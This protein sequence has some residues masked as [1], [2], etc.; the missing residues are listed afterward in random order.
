MKQ[1]FDADVLVNVG[2]M[3]SLAGSDE[4]KV[5]P[6]RGRGFRQPPRPSQRHADN[7]TVDQ[8]GDDLVLGHAYLLNAR[9]VADASHSVHTT[10]LE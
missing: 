1:S 9:I 4:T 3:D 7:T 6:L 2:P 10:S 5:C 8:I